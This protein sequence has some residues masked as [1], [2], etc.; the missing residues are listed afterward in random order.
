[1]AVF[2]AAFRIGRQADSQV[3]SLS[4]RASRSIRVKNN[5]APLQNYVTYDTLA[6]TNIELRLF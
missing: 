3:G 5:P 6:A 4:R 1:M 2:L